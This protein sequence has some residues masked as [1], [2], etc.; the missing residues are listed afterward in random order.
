[1]CV[2]VDLL[3][4]PTLYTELGINIVTY[5]YNTFEKGGVETIFT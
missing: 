1:M 2:C 3:I 4:K 5:I